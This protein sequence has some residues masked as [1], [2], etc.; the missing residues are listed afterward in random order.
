MDSPDRR[1]FRLVSRDGGPDVTIVGPAAV[2]GRHPDCD[3]WLDAL[4]V[5]RR[6]CFVATTEG[7]LMVRDLGSLNGTL[8]NGR[9][10]VRRDL[11]PGDELTIGTFRFL[12]TEG[13]DG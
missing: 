10:V 6:H 13:A 11:A 2:F 9:R 7:R 12:V 3:V 1:T 5:S 4:A 8:V